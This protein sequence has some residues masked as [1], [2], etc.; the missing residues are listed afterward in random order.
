MFKVGDIITGL[1]KKQYAITNSLGTYEVVEVLNN[2]KITVRVLTHEYY[3]GYIGGTY[4]VDSE[5]F[6]LV[7]P[8]YPQAAVLKKIAHLRN[9]FE[10]RKK[11]KE[12]E[13]KYY[14]QEYTMVS[15][16]ALIV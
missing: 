8:V 9:L 14:T 7:E 2:H 15:L 4:P 3:R 12:V 16:D 5:K 6:Q 1:T 11:E 13:I 10:N